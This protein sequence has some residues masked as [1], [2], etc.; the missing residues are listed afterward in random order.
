MLPAD[1]S[2]R[3]R[4]PGLVRDKERAANKQ[5][6]PERAQ[7]NVVLA[8]DVAPAHLADQLER[9]RPTNHREWKIAIA[10]NL[11]D[12]ADL[13]TQGDELTRQQIRNRF[14]PA[15]TREKMMRTEKNFHARNQAP[16]NSRKDGR[17]RIRPA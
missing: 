16:T 3:V 12:D 10:R 8:K 7:R 2:I 5:Q 6:R 1:A 17:D 15:G 11:S 9:F 14:D 4:D 13:V